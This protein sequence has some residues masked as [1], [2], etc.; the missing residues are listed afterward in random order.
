MRVEGKKGAEGGFAE[1]GKM[2][3]SRCCFRVEYM[4]I[5]YFDLS[6]ILI[7]VLMIAILFQRKV[8]G[9]RTNE[10][11]MALYLN[12]L[13]TTIFDLWSEAY[14]VWFLAQDSDR[15]YRAEFVHEAVHA[16][17]SDG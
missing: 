17:G 2:L 1:N 14:N 10:L 8:Q 6:A 9:S 5:L 15:I 11:L 4:K 13:L 3:L 12:V 16:D 7:M